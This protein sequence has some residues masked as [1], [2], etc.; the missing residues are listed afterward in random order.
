[1]RSLMAS[2]LLVLSLGAALAW[3]EPGNVIATVAISHFMAEAVR[4]PRSA[5]TYRAM[6]DAACSRMPSNTPVLAV[7]YFLK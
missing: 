3:G 6:V 7:L 5:V 4:L 2:I 1:M